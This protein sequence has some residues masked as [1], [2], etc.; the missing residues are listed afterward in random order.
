MLAESGF[1]VG[2]GDGGAAVEDKAGTGPLAG[3]LGHLFEVAKDT[4]FQVIDL[5]EALLEHEG[6]RLLAAN[7]ACAEHRDLRG[8][9]GIEMLADG[10]G[11]VGEGVDVWIDGVGEGTELDLVL[12]AGVEQEEVR[13]RDEVVP[14]PGLDVGAG[15]SGVDVG[16][17]EGDDFGAEEELEAAEGAGVGGRELDLGAGKAGAL[18]KEG[19]ETVDRV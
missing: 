14:L 4:A 11:E 3:G 17:A 5:F 10:G 15:A 6:G 16:V 13:V 12:V 9:G 1:E 19:E 7:A 18:L 2:V 8:A